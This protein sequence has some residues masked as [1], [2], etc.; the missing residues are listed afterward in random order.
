MLEKT[1]SKENPN[2]FKLVINS[3]IVKKYFKETALTKKEIQKIAKDIDSLELRQRV[4]LIAYEL[5]KV[6]PDDFSVALSKLLQITRKQNLES[7][8]LW[9]ATEFIQIYGLNHIEKSLT[10]MYEL[11]QK[12]TAEF[13]IRPFINKYGAEIYEKLEA[14]KHD[15]N[16]HIRR[17]LSEGTRPRLPWGEKLQLAVEN[18]SYGLEILEHL[19]FDP[20]LYVRKSVANHLNDIAKDHPTIVVQTLIRWKKQVPEN[21]QKE[22]QF[23]TNRAL[24]TLIKNGNTDALKFSGIETNNN[25]I[26]QSELKINKTKFKM[27]DI[28]EMTFLITNTSKKRIKFIVDFVIYFQKANGQL[29]PKV[30]KLKNGFLES[31]QQLSIA[32]KYA[33]RPITTRKFHSGI[34]HLTIKLN[35][36][37]SKR[38]KFELNT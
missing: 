17:W 1:M 2:A 38:L 25:S 22:F 19:K 32:K 26:N 29:K 9:P 36:I 27:G 12:F 14:W 33:F 20:S 31:K 8:E 13:S 18:P 3:A 4:Q 10:A 34:H 35:G 30:F 15:E 23:I 24:R 21:Y 37:E 6:L 11:T 7:F 28:L 5:K 16:E